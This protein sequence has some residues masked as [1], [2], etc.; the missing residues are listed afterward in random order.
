MHYNCVKRFYKDRATLMYTGRAK[1]GCKTIPSKCL[2]FF[3]F[4]ITDT[5][6]LIYKLET[7]DMYADMMKNSFYFDLHEYE[8]PFAQYRHE[9][10]KQVKQM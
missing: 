6:S 9:G 2:C 7:E 8:G 10:N 5:D 4:L 3:F 1:T